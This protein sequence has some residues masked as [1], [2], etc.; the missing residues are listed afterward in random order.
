MKLL[1][2]L[3]GSTMVMSME[4]GGDVVV[5]VFS[6]SSC[7]FYSI[8]KLYERL[9]RCFTTIFRICGELLIFVTLSLYVIRSRSG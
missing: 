5:K 6:A 2:C 9:V 3:N 4:G 7:I 8:S 1:H